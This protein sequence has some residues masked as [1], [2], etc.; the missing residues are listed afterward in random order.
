MIF[1]SAEITTLDLWPV[2]QDADPYWR[3]EV[4]TLQL[5]ERR[6]MRERGGGGGARHLQHRRVILVER[7]RRGQQPLRGR[8]VPKVLLQVRE[9][10]E[11]VPVLRLEGQRLRVELARSVHTACAPGTG[12]EGRPGVSSEMTVSSRLPIR[13]EETEHRNG[14]GAPQRGQG[15]FDLVWH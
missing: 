6:D 15:E 2:S 12:R 7:V 5:G 9:R 13:G 11:R 14:E 8:Q 4:E 3:H 1:S 10:H